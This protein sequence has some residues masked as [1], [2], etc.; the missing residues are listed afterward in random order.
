MNT[1]MDGGAGFVRLPLRGQLRLGAR[2]RR[3]TF[4]IPV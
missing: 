3:A 1:V 2:L 4:L